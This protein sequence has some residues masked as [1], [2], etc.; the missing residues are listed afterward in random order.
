MKD[1]GELENHLRCYGTLDKLWNCPRCYLRNGQLSE[2]D[3]DEM[4]FKYHI[5]RDEPTLCNGALTH[6]LDELAMAFHAAWMKLVNFH[7]PGQYSSKAV[8]AR[9]AQAAFRVVRDE[10]DEAFSTLLSACELVRQGRL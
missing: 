6:R 2:L 3:T 9:E 10:Y 7:H 1:T 5:Y 8:K 4:G